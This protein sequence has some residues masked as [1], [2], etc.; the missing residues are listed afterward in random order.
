MLGR[1]ATIYLP[2]PF[3]IEHRPPTPHP[4]SLLLYMYLYMAL[5]SGTPL[6]MWCTCTVAGLS[7]NLEKQSEAGVAVDLDANLAHMDT[8][9]FC[10]VRE[11]SKLLFCVKYSKTCKER[12]P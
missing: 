1:K 3:S 12:T 4:E 5:V 7:Y 8:L 6:L 2:I 11:N 10:L 9:E